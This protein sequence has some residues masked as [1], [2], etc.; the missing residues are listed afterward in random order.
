MVEEQISHMKIMLHVVCLLMMLYGEFRDD[1]PDGLDLSGKQQRILH[2]E[3][4]LACFSVDDTGWLMSSFNK[5]ARV[6]QIWLDPRQ[7]QAI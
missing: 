3:L 4:W 6:R 7:D 1:V 5:L 2:R